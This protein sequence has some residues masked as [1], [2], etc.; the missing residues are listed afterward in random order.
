VFT[1]RDSIF[2]CVAEDLQI[3]VRG[4]SIASAA[5]EFSGRLFE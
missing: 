1:F 3:E 2:E 4:G 5:A